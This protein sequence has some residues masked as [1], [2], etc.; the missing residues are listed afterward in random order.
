MTKKII[1]QVDE[2]YKNVILEEVRNTEC[3]SIQAF[4]LNLYKHLKALGGMLIQA[5]VA[6]IDEKIKKRYIVDEGEILTCKEIR[7]RNFYSLFGKIPIF[8]SYYHRKGCKGVYPVDKIIA[9]PDQIYSY[10]LEK[11]VALLFSNSTLEHT[12]TVL[13]EVY[14]IKLCDRVM[15]DIFLKMSKYADHFR[16]LQEPKMTLGKEHIFVIA[17]DGKGVKMRKNAL[18]GVK[19]KDGDAKTKQATLVVTYFKLIHVRTAKDFIRE[20]RSK[21]EEMEK[22]KKDRKMEK[23]LRPVGK[24]VYAKL[25]SKE[26]AFLF[27]KWQIKKHEAQNYQK[28]VLITDGDKSL[29]KKAM[30]HLR[31]YVHI[32][33]IYHTLERLWK[34]AHQFYDNGSDESRSYVD[35]KLELLL[36]GQFKEFI[37]QLTKEKKSLKGAKH[38]VFKENIKYFRP[39]SEMMKYDEYLAKGYPIGSGAVESAC[40]N[41]VKQRMEGSG[42]F[43]SWKGAQAMLD[44]RSI[45]LNGD[46]DKFFEFYVRECGEK[47]SGMKKYQKEKLFA[48][49]Q[50]RNNKC[51]KNIG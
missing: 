48:T 4:E 1:A 7:K 20:L 38:K 23:A 40:K 12:V 35:N 18:K 39:R 44:I 15:L 17:I 11:L 19:G 30:K 29:S 21:S 43:W 16:A 24:E 9:L 8:S 46:L 31:N 41:L 34:C 5:K 33:D 49:K 2:F 47:T 14:G 36:T 10:N 13:E 25:A 50:K 42:M 32:L 28:T 22:Q 26:K 6:A 3:E 45:Y 51:N 37:A 27:A